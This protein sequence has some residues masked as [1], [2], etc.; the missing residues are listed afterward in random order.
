MP[1]DVCNA[2]NL[3]GMPSHHKKE[4]AQS[5]QINQDFGNIADT[6]IIPKLDNLPFGSSAKLSWQGAYGKQRGLRQARQS[7]LRRATAH[8]SYRSLLPNADVSFSCPF[9]SMLLW[10]GSRELGSNRK[11]AFLNLLEQR[12][13]LG[14]YANGSSTPSTAFNSSTDPYEQI[15]GSSLLTRGPPNNPVVP[16]SPVLVYIFIVI[17]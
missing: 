16:A 13:V 8:Q 10:F 17:C 5:V 4:I 3:V 7:S 14:I 12:I 15:R 2:Q 1:R 11:K 9:Q 6:R